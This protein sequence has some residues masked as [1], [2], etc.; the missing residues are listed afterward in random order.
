MQKTG[1]SVR[2]PPE[3]YLVH[4]GGDGSVR[5]GRAILHLMQPR[6]RARKLGPGAPALLVQQHHRGLEPG[7]RCLESG[8]LH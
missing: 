3:I 1:V 4:K 8:H 5:L 6:A 2:L 7:V